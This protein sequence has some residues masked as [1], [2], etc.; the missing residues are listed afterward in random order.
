[1]IKKGKLSMQKEHV[2]IF[3]IYAIIGGVLGG[4]IGQFIFW[5][6]QIIISNPLEILKIWHGGMAIHGGILGFLFATYLF[7][8]K[9]KVKIYNITDNVVLPTA[10]VLIFGRIA[11]FINAELVGTVTNV[12]WAVNWFG[13][14]NK[15]G[16]LVGRHPSQI[17]E[18]FKNLG[19]A[20]TL[21]LLSIKENV[22]GKYKEGFYTWMFIFLYGTLR[23]I[24]NIWREETSRWFFGIFGTGQ[25]LSLIMA[26]IAGI[27]LI[28]NYRHK[29]KSENKTNKKINLKRKINL[30][31]NT[32]NKKRNKKWKK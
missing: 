25:V 22:L 8:K 26:I 16:E 24:A 27:I 6:P 18:S 7:S 15:A 31:K 4:R 23:T 9:Y 19:I 28:K 12:P 17:Y 10:I 1:M 30:K 2:D 20:I 21:Y 32:K 14:T 5:Q 29:H 11:N 3:M 13:E